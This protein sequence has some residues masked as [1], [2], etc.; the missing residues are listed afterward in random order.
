[1]I[2]VAVVYTVVAWAAVEAAS[3]IFP[4]LLLPDWTER[5]VVALALLGFPVALALAWAFEVRPEGAAAEAPTAAPEPVGEERLD[6]WKRIAAYL[7]RDVRTVRR[8][9]KDRNLPVRRI[10]HDKLATVYAYRSELD[11]W[12][13]RRDTAAPAKPDRKRRIRGKPGPRWLAVALPALVIGAAVIWFMRGDDETPITLGQW[14]WVL[15]TEFENRSGEE[16]LD[17]IGE[18]ALARELANSGYVKVAPPGR[19]Q[20]ALRLMQLPPDTPIDV[21]VGREISL[22]DGGIR[23]LISGRVDKLGNTYSISSELVNPSDGVTVASF[24]AEARSQDDILPQMSELASRV[25]E[26]LG[27]SLASIQASE[28]MLSKVTTPS[29][30]ALRLYSQAESLMRGPERNRA[31]P[32]LEQALRV[33]PDFASAHV[34]LSYVLRDRNEYERSEQQLQ[35]AV[36]LA[37]QATERERLFILATYYRYLEDLPQEIETY[38]LLVR[39]YPDH[40]WANG[41][42]ALIFGWQGRFADA[43][44]PRARA[45]ESVPNN[46]FAQYLTSIYAAAAGETEKAE[47]FRDRAVTLAGDVPWM[48]SMVQLQPIHSAWMSGDNAKASSM[49]EELLAELSSEQLLANGR[50]YSDV[51]SMLMSLGRLERFRELS[52]LRPQLG[53]LEAMVDYASGNPATLEGY[54]EEQD[55]GFWMATLL[56]MTGKTE[57]A[58][59]LIEDPRS[60]EALPPPYLVRDWHNLANGQLALAEGQLERAVELLSRETRILFISAPYAHQ[61]GMNSLARA[62][63]SLD[64]VEQAIETLEFVRRQKPVTIIDAGAQWFWQRNMALLYEI[65]RDR[66]ETAKMLSVADELREVL[67]L[68]DEGH[69]FLQRIELD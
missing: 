34:L 63:L 24:S 17:G 11:E 1:V 48:Q 60:A 52:R 51:R 46:F 9:E 4:A 47:V 35:R 18:Y 61:F 56:A 44:P 21:A 5:L 6:G 29:L 22:R 23:M 14:D 20:D 54:L 59:A 25:R 38:E 26:S 64:Q 19:V 30:E 37:D 66:G 2:R 32:I 55:V 31:I 28:V 57:R 3:V 50:L 39:L 45:A 8:W 58:R 67:S 41:N 69:P 10:M 12:M 65:Y 15:V 42:L 43:L 36:E 49:I 40:A 16:V 7:N 62:Y 13:T 27:E 53:W 68:A 33:D